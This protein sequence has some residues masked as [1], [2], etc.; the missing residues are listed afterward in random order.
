MAIVCV[1]CVI[2]PWI[3]IAILPLCVSFII[4]R[5]YY[6]QTS[7]HVKRLEGKSWY[8]LFF[9]TFRHIRIVF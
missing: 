3:L 6:L 8:C 9:L 7:R 2:N 4:I 5:Q 1:A